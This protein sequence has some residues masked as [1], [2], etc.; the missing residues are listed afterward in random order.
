M[1]LLQWNINGFSTKK[2]YLQILTTKSKFDCICL[3]E[4]N[5][6]L[7]YCY[8]LSGYQAVYK[9]RHNNRRASGGV[10][11]YVNNDVD[12]SQIPLNTNLE[13]VAVRINSPY[14]LTVCNIYLPNSTKLDIGDLAHLENQLI[15]PYIVVGDF[16][17]HNAIWGSN[18]TDTRGKLIEHWIDNSE[19]LILLNNGYNTHFSVS[20]GQHSVID[21][22]LSSKEIAP[23]L[24]WEAMN[25]LYDSDHNPII[26]N[27]CRQ[28][29]YQNHN[30]RYLRWRL[31]SG[32]LDTLQ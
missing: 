11:I 32:R 2:E 13:A 15:S 29:N 12:I 4:T 10:V 17:G 27:D 26:V 16:N 25:D 28:T 9:N 21:L 24:N 5:F 14:A 18:Y 3:Q 8:N 6:K 20:S 7:D 31:Q 23:Y 1:K 19:E 22:S 30:T